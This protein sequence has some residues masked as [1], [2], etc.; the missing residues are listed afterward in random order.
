MLKRK[1][2]AFG[3]NKP[4]QRK[5]L[6]FST[7][8]LI[9]TLASGT[10]TANALPQRDIRKFSL[11]EDIQK[12]ECNPDVERLLKKG[13]RI[14]ESICM[15]NHDFVLTNTSLIIVNRHNPD[16]QKGGIKIVASFSKTD[17]RDIFKQGHVDWA[18]SEETVFFLTK[19][20]VLTLIPVEQMG[21]T[22]EAYRLSC[23]V[24]NAKLAYHSDHLFI[25]GQGEIIATSFSNGVSSVSVPF[26]LEV[27]NPDFF[28]SAGKLFF[29]NGKQKV[30]IKINGEEVQLR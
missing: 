17:M 23:N 8:A 30:E 7:V 14:Q 22:V 16:R 6:F 27:K 24:K 18:A 29:G 1:T 3:K 15:I 20:G 25:A 12:R 28:E 2:L 13:E 9:A 21:D 4:E 11:K 26:S 5:S 10:V 19:D